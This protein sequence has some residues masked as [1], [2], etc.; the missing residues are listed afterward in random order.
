MKESTQELQSICRNR[1]PAKNGG[2][3]IS[4]SGSLF[5]DFDF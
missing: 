1:K 2:F 5:L 3:S 4:T